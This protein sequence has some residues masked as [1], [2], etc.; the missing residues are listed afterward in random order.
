VVV[1][2]SAKINIGL[3]VI[4]R[5]PDGFHDIETLFYPVALCDILE[6]VPAKELSLQLFGLPVE[7]PMEHNLCVKA[8]RLLQK[9][10]DLPPVAMYLYKKIPPVAG[11][12]GGS[13]DATHTLLALNRLFHLNLTNP[14]LHN[15]AAQ[16]GSDCAFFLHNKP[17]LATGRGDQLREM[18]HVCLQG[19]HVVLV[20]PA[21][22][23]VSTA[24]AYAA[25][26]PQQ[27]AGPLTGVLAHPVSEWQQLIGNDFEAPVFSQFPELQRI[28]TQLYRQGALYAAMSGS[29]SSI[30]GLFPNQ[31]TAESA[32]REMNPHVLFTGPLN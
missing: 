4:A 27:P 26:V 13:S 7:G 17:M 12:G 30:Y 18:P 29:G 32:A 16:L 22:V 15:Y 10:R 2:P 3:R 19:Y 21:A 25:V 8:Y 14:Q 20:K 9:D 11:L 1:F 31:E 5:R 24:A 23:C 28:K 6:I